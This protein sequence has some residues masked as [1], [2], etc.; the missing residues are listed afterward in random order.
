M[1]GDRWP[2]RAKIIKAKEPRCD[3]ITDTIMPFQLP[4]ADG[5]L[6]KNTGGSTL[7]GKRLR[8]GW[9]K[10]KYSGVGHRY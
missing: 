7:N 6:K 10:Q 9:E 3:A 1:I 8:E 4:F 5:K 2:L